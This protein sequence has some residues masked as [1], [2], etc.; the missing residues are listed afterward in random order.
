MYVRARK[1]R[2]RTGHTAAGRGPYFKSFLCRRLSFRGPK[3]CISAE[4]LQM[5]LR[6]IRRSIARLPADQC[7][8]VIETD[9]TALRGGEVAPRF[10]SAPLHLIPHAEPDDPNQQYRLALPHHGLVYQDCISCRAPTAPRHCEGPHR[11][12]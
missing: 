4:A 10:A 3:P 12:E 8:A 5:N 6:A 7:R 2:A 11:S 9:A 1:L